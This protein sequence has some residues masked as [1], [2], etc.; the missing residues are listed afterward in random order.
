MPVE[1]DSP[2]RLSEIPDD[3]TREVKRKARKPMERADYTRAPLGDDEIGSG[4]RVRH[5]HW[6]EGTV[7]E[8]IGTGEGAE[9]VVAFDAQGDKRLLLAWAPIERV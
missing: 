4:D 5:S 2:T 6:G 3:L 1:A 8:V 9:A 7:R